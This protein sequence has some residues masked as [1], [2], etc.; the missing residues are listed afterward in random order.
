MNTIG[1]LCTGYGGLDEAAKAFFDAKTV[2]VADNDP[3]VC[4]WLS[5]ALPDVPNLGDITKID[6][7]KVRSVDIL[8][9]GYPCQPF[10]LAGKRKGTEDNRHIW[11]YIREAVRVLRPHHVFLEN[12]PGHRIRGFGE[13]LGDLAEMRYD[14]RWV[15]LPASAVGAPH[16]RERV[17]ILATD[18][19]SSRQLRDG[20][21]SSRS[22]RGDEPSDLRHSPHEW[23]IADDGTDYTAT[24]RRW[25][26][27]TGHVAPPPKVRSKRT[28][29]GWVLNEKFVEWMMG[30][31]PGHITAKSLPVGAQKKMAGNGVVP[32]Q[33]YRALEILFEE[34]F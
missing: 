23:W 24:I 5:E 29:S 4:K 17:F 33:A 28:R 34:E 6:W 16:R 15:S 1:S 10:S 22:F 13:V 18:A 26:R 3:Q 21:R 7:T 14:A 12:V 32:Q 2:W 31:A 27:V 25:E 20:G 9:A 8:T 11:P 19:D 30:L